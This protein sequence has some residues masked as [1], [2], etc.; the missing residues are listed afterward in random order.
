M[1]SIIFLGVIGPVEHDYDGFRAQNSPKS[2][3]TMR[4]QNGHGPFSDKLWRFY[5]PD[6]NAFRKLK[7][8]SYAVFDALQNEIYFDFGLEENFRATCESSHFGEAQKS[9]KRAHRLH[10][11]RILKFWVC[12]SILRKILHQISYFG[13]QNQTSAAQTKIKLKIALK[14]TNFFRKFQ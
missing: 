8:L 12:H 4:S 10:K 11:S 2:I 13:E 9:K 7:A 1:T 5:P 3:R 6:V 14:M